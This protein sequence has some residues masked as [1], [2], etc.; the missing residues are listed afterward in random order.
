MRRLFWQLLV[1]F[2]FPFLAIC[3]APRATAAQGGT[4]RGRVV[5]SA[6]IAIAQAVVSA[7]PGG[8]RAT[9]R[10]NGDYA[11]THVPAGV[12]TLRVRRLGYLTPATSLTIAE[13][14]TVTQNFTV[15]HSVVSLAEVVIGSRAR[16]TAADELPVP[17]DV[18]TPEMIQAQG[19]TET[20]Q[21]LS[22]LSASVNFPRQSVSDAT[23]IVRPFTM[24]G[25]S[26]DH[27]LV[28]INGKRRHHTALIHYYGA[29]E[30]AGSSGIDMNSIPASAVG[31]IEV[32]RDGAAAQYGSDAIAGVVNVLLKDGTTSPFLTAD[33]G[34]YFTSK[35]NPAALPD[36]GGSRPAYPHDGRT[37]DV[38]GGWG[39]PLGRGSLGL[40]AEY[41]DRQ[42]TNRAGPDPTDM[43]V[44]GDADGVVDG[45]LVAKNNSIAMP[46][47]HWGDGASK[48]LMTFFNAS[49]PFSPSNAGAGLYAFGGYSYRQGAGFGYFRP[50]SSERN[51]PQ[52]YPN[53]FL[54]K[55]APDVLD[56]SGAGG[57]R[58]VMSG[59]SYDLGGTLGHNGFKYNLENTLNTS[60]G[61]CLTTACAPG[62]DGVLGTADDPG[63]PNKTS[64]FAGELKYTE[65]ILSLDASHEYAAGLASPLNVAVG[66]AFRTERYVIGAGEAASYIN[67]FHPAQDGSIAPSGSQVFPGFRPQDAANAN[68]NN[69][70]A[71]V[72]LE[73]DLVPRVLADVAARYEHYSDF[74]SKVTGKVAMRY[75]PTSQLTLRSAVSTGFRA[76]SLNQSYFS[77]VVTNFAADPNTG[78]PVPFEIGIFPVNSREARALGARPLKPESSK[79]F[80]AG[81]ALTPV[82]NLT[83]TS[84]FYYIAINDRITITGF[85]G[86]GTDSV[87]RILANIGSPA[88]TAQYFTNA[89][90]TRTK[91]V[92]LTGNYSLETLGGT[93]GLNAIFNFTRTTIPNEDNIPLPPELQGTGVT[94]V[95]KYDEGG[96]LA[97][98]KE[99]PAWRGTVTGTYARGA[100]NGMARYAYYG[101][102]TSAL[103]SYSGSDVQNYRGKSL[104]DAEL[105][106][107]PMQGFKLSI[108]GR[109]LFDVYPDR[110]NEGNGFDIFPWPPA[111]PFGYNGRYLYTRLEVTGR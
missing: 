34:E 110:M 45:N 39:I 69:I 15:T 95:N 26:P 107:S 22:Q 55:F 102:Y 82:E 16:H 29:G 80:S 10:D 49:F 71:Y 59:W 111:S 43:F 73:A 65:A 46:N 60:L 41:R 40:F 91:G 48:D 93:A 2:G 96:L 76:P 70:G 27:T 77:S 44:A 63:I 64:I 88:T 57:V 87:S 100:W 62:A 1:V 78:N 36:A 81:F 33:L 8:L 24:R 31:R 106:F 9:T 97:I 74:G 32:L 14:Q 108:G 13:G 12:Y 5:D 99:R 6:G 109:N 61:P 18:F 52:I 84:D 38:N 37:V 23:E 79:N 85:L 86:D 103:Y 50:P 92:D 94:L 30:G 98:T 101:K 51:W 68:R 66:T 21:I 105:G 11:I 25:L 42:P 28:L 58:G 53:G 90:D 83:F 54:P 89:I 7:D 3:L 19:T 47:H 4:V 17:V 67:G 75:Q 104:V 20:A 72:D 35:E 56:F